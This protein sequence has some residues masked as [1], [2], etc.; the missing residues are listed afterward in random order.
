MNIRELSCISLK[1]AVT[2]CSIH[3]CHAIDIVYHLNLS[4][5][6]LYQF[7]FTEVYYNWQIL[8]FTKPWLENWLKFVSTVPVSI[9]CTVK[10]EAYKR[11]RLVLWPTNLTL[12]LHG[13]SI[14]Y[15]FSNATFCNY[16]FCFYAS[17]WLTRGTFIDLQYTSYLATDNFKVVNS[18]LPF[19]FTQTSGSCCVQCSLL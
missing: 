17:V 13:S 10:W 18:Y 2:T 3:A 15:L 1:Q 11:Q 14:Y 4:N 16:C 5:I 19:S 7:A 12:T 8:Q 9:K 6:V